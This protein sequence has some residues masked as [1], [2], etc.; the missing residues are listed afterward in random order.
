MFQKMKDR[1]T[2]AA[3]D[4]RLDKTKAS[5]KKAETGI[6][7]ALEPVGRW[8]NR[9]AGKL[10]AESFWPTTMDLECDKAARILRTFTVTG[11]QADSDPAAERTG[12]VV[13]G[14]TKTPEQIERERKEHKYDD[15]KTQKVVKKIPA[16]VIAQAKGIAI[17]TV[18]RTGLGFSGAGGSGVVLKRLPDGSWSG[19][20][21][22]LLHT[23]GWGLLIG[24]DIYDVILVLRT[25]K[26]VEAFR[27]PKISVGAEIAVAAGPVGNG[28]MI[29][30]GP[31]ASPA[32]SY[33]KSKGFY[34]GL[35]LDGNIILKRKD[36]NSR[37]YGIPD[38]STADIFSG[39]IPPPRAAYPLLKTLY[40]AE[41]RSPP[42][43]ASYL[44]AADVFIPEGPAP[45]DTVLSA[46]DAAALEAESKAQEQGQGQGQGQG[47]IA[48]GSGSV[49]AAT[50]SST[51]AHPVDPHYQPAPAGTAAV[52]DPASLA[53]IGGGAA[54][55]GAGL[56]AAAGY[57]AT[58]HQQSQ[59]V[60]HQQQPPV[61]SRKESEV[62]EQPPPDYDFGSAPLSTNPGLA[63]AQPGGTTANPYAAGAP[64]AL[65]A[66]P[67][68]TPYTAPPPPPASGAPLSAA[69]EKERFRQR[70]AAERAAALGGAG[71]GSSSGS[72]S[73]A[74]PP[75]PSHPTTVGSASTTTTSYYA[76]PAG[77]PPP[78]SA[79]APQAQA[80][81][82]AQMQSNPYAA[83]QPPASASGAGAGAGAGGQLSAE[84][85][86]E[87]FRQREAAE[88]AA[89]Q[90]AVASANAGAA[91]SSSGAGG[92]GVAPPNL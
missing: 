34:A 23:I 50:N 47:Q 25:D 74:L 19:P 32:F 24:L 27:N 33:V 81:A 16:E 11:A 91:G 26:A 82:Q 13:G 53:A 62:W 14:A 80:Q 89:A 30:S 1:V 65:S 57:A 92:A 63:N 12:G 58:H 41:G 5:L 79:A 78:P 21:G 43:T 68:P 54:A 9:T 87:R 51:A 59:P 55:A 86:K 64:T 46:E 84:E 20:S 48:S 61:P 4:P 44:G 77:P 8:S 17:F 29:D 73:A 2:A 28:A 69:E 71:A 90:A 7:K 60:Q 37:F 85:E 72:G 45:G 35:Q 10:G 39:R 75:P 3:A 76:P 6:W 22:L 31:E 49:A 18:F 40:A 70:E 66:A 42:S 88:R 36:E 56:G 52:H 15:R 83:G 67:A 38:V